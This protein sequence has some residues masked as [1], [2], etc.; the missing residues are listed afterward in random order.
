V[1]K[2]VLALVL[3]AL[4]MGL[5]SGDIAVQARGES[6]AEGAVAGAVHLV[7]DTANDL[8]C[9][10]FGTQEEAQAVLDD[11]PSDPNNLDPN[12]DAIACALLPA[13]ED[14]DT[15][16]EA[17]V[18]AAQAAQD[19]EQP[20][21]ERR[22]NRDRQAAQEE[23][24]PRTCADF[25]TAEDAQAAFDE[26]P[27]G[28]AALDEDGNG[29]ACEELLVAEPAEDDTTERRQNRRNRDEEPADTAVDE[30]A[31]LPAEDLDCVDFDFQE[32]AQEIYN[33]DPSDPFNLDPNGDGFACSSLPSRD[34]L[35]SQV[36][37]TGAGQSVPASAFL[38]AAAILAGIAAGGL[39]R[40]NNRAVIPRAVSTSRR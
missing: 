17:D 32:E 26:D 15:A 19:E 36:P 13:E 25:E 18:E 6:R 7:Q 9:E 5:A 16:P 11:D 39:S 34:P 28:L 1:G 2:Q 33:Q 38:A 4:L 24:A 31:A 22:R 12:G 37:R 3:V 14:G 27:G 10:D 35:I 21:T 23:P 40:G 30:P 8:D 29:I 20:R